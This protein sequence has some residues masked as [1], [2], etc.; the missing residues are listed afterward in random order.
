MLADYHL[1]TPLCK[2]AVGA[3]R[4]YVARA[5]ELGLVEIAFTDHVPAPSGYDPAFRMELR[6]FPAYRRRVAEAAR[7]AP[8]PVRFG[9]EADYTPA[10]LPFLERWLPEQGFDLVLGSVHY[11]GDWGFDNPDNQAGWVGREVASVWREYFGLVG[12]LAD[13]RLFDVLGHLDLP[14]KFGHR[15]AE[16][17]LREL[18]QPALD[19][20]AAAGMALEINTAGLRK[21]VGEMYPSLLLLE[22]A[23]QREIPITFGSDAHAPAEVGQAFDQALALARAAG[24]DAYCRFAGR[25]A[26]RTPLPAPK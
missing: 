19:R 24:Y 6:Q 11:I 9:I 17:A 4:E 13:T 5:A 20:L 10:E 22:L 15:L 8:L 23:R 3:P 2:H 14:K 7:D 1:H 25:R 12:A 26:Q 16:A 18:A 21:P